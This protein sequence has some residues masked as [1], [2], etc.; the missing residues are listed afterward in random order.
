MIQRDRYL[1]AAVVVVLIS[2]AYWSMFSFNAYNTYHEY[3]DVGEAAYDMY[4]HVNFP[5][6]L[7]GLQYM[8]FESHI[9]P[10]QLFIMSFFALAPSA[11]TLLVIQAF[12]VSM[13]GLA[14]FFVARDLLKS[15]GI[16]LLLCVAFILSPGI[17]GILAFD[18]HTEM[19]IPLFVVLTFYFMMKRRPVLF[20]VALLLLL[21]IIEISPF[22]A[23]LLA[24]AMGLYAFAREKP[25]P[26]RRSLLIYAGAMLVVSVVA[27]GIY[28]AIAASVNNA[29]LAGAYPGMPQIFKV[30]DVVAHQLGSLGTGGLTLAFSSLPLYTLFALAIIFLGFGFAGLLDP[31]FAL[32]FTAPWLIEVFLVGNTNFVVT[33]NQYFSY[34]IGGAVIATILALKRI[35]DQEHHHNALSFFKHGQKISKY[36]VWSIIVCSVILLLLSPHFI[37]SKNINNIGQDFLFQVA[38]AEHAQIGQLTSM[39]ALVPANASVMAPYFAM[40]HLV[41]REYFELIPDTVNDYMVLPANASAVDSTGMWFQ[42]QY[43]LADFN[44]YISLNA[45]SG[46]QLQNFINITG[47]VITGNGTADFAGPYE[48]DAYN[49]SAILLRKKS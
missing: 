22:I 33:W 23:A 39:I 32:L 47:V 19:L 31:V 4:Y 9:S 3:A 38:P 21:G 1:L 12:I 35:H 20:A 7:H 26:E 37:Y 8:V 46:Y 30:G 10:D 41:N 44:A 11:L 18:Y 13:T 16:A 25:G 6:V 15:P 49:G 40:P 42:P 24:V 28:G 36:A 45:E 48:I 14:I 27:F 17:Q 5:S 34:A 29:Y 2:T 43:V